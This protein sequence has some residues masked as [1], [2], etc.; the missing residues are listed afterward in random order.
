MCRDS[1]KP[2]E[3]QLAEEV[4]LKEPIPLR[5]EH[6]NRYMVLDKTSQ[7]M[8]SCRHDELPGRRRDEASLRR[9]KIV[10]WEMHVHLV[11]V[12]I[13]IESLAVG[14]VE[15]KRLLTSTD[16]AASS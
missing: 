10:L 5:E 14:I 9:R 16:T 12:E 1:L 13:C 11:P 6:T 2:L 8:T 7:G 4:F 3:D 15:S